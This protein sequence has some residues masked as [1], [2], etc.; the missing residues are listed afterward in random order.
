MRLVGATLA[1]L[2]VL[3]SI[4]TALAQTS[5]DSETVVDQLAQARTAADLERAMALFADDAVITIQSGRA[6]QV[7]LDVNR[8]ERICEVC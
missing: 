6:T 5:N 4:G 7:L 2:L 1:V 3:L 8:Y